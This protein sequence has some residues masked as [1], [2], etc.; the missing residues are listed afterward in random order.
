MNEALTIGIVT[1]GPA[2]MLSNTLA[3]IS[4]SIQDFD[5]PCHV[6]IANNSGPTNRSNVE[7]S[8][9]KSGIESVAPVKVVDSPENNISV[10]RN[11][12]LDNTKTRILIFIDDDIL[13]VTNWVRSHW[14]QY[15]QSECGAVAGPVRSVFPDSAPNW[16]RNLDLHNADGKKTGDVIPIAPTGNV[17]IDL[18]KSKSLRFDKK[19]GLTGG[20]DSFFFQALTRAGHAIIWSEDAEVTEIVPEERGNAK[21]MIFRFMKQGNN[22]KRVVFHNQNILFK[23]KFFIKAIVIAPPSIIAGYLLMPFNSKYCALWLKRGF[24]NLGKLFRHPANLYGK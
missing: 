24:T 23:V 10:G 8:V 18:H 9:S 11:I 16:I 15:S 22:Y 14:E 12:V 5:S 17:L 4:E 3:A 19:Y 2:T 6:L 1:Y 21:Y 20:G 13:P 7:Q